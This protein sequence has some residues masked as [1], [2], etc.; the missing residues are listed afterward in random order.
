MKRTV[1][2]AMQWLM[3]TINDECRS[4]RALIL[5]KDFEDEIVCGDL[6]K[7]P[8]GAAADILTAVTVLLTAAAEDFDFREER[9]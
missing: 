7:D 4:G 6:C 9:G 2:E 3:Q 8:K 5:A 1:L